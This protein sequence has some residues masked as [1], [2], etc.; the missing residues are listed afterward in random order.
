MDIET[1]SFQNKARRGV[2]YLSSK[3]VVGHLQV[4]VIVVRASSSFFEEKKAGSVTLLAK[5]TGWNLK[6]RKGV[7]VQPSLQGCGRLRAPPLCGLG[8]LCEHYKFPQWVQG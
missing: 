5:T 1:V 3:L 2:D 4:R 8:G 6:I 7:E